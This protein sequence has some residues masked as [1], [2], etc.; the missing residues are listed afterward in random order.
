M[1]VLR[2]AGPFAFLAAVP[3]S[4]GWSVSA[5]FAVPAALLFLLLIASYLPEPEAAK[6]TLHR[7]LPIL[8]IPLQLAVIVW[9]LHQVSVERNG[10]AGFLSLALA[11]GVCTGVFGVLAAHEMVHSRVR[12]QHLL[13][14]AMLTAMSYRHFRIAHVY[15]HHRH[16]ATIRDP[17]TA[18]LGESFYAFFG[19]T[20]RQQLAEAWQFE[21]HRVRR[22]A[23][24]F[25]YNRVHRDI[26]LMLSIYA[27]LWFSFGWRAAV[28]LACESLAAIAVLELFNYAAHY[29]LSRR[30]GERMTAHH[31]W[32][33]PGASNLLIFNMGRHSHHH[34]SPALAFDGLTAA[35]GAPVLPGGYAGAILLA[36]VPPLWRGV[37]HPRLGCPATQG[38]ESVYGDSSRPAAATP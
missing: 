25:L 2:F 18:R 7:F 24:P 33:S 23:L 10:V 21:K 14:T 8:Y 4:Y 37:I 9:A 29:G 38:R 22:R 6:S 27:A 13:G 36:L 11:T 28:F 30:D 31:S 3:I 20:L 32:N 34:R 15:G 12:W 19:R 35:P 5:P 17:A 1:N 26:A 16:A